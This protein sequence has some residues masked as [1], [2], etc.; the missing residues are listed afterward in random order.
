MG[1]HLYSLLLLLCAPLLIAHVVRKYGRENCDPMVGRRLGINIPDQVDACLWIHACSLGEAKVALE[2]ARALVKHDSSLHV[3]MT[4]TTPV[5]LHLL[6]RSEFASHVFPWDF[7]WVWSRWLARLRP[8]ALVVIETELWPNLVAACYQ[9]AVPVILANG[10]LSDQSVRR[11]G[12]FGWVSRPMW[13]KV[14]RALMQFDGDVHHAHSLGVPAHAISEVGSIKVDQPAPQISWER[15][16]QISDWKRGH[17]L[18]CLM[19]SHADDDALLVA[20]ALQH[21]ELRLLIVPRHPVRGPEIKTLADNHGLVAS[22]VSAEIED[23]AKILIG[24]TFGDMGAYLSQSDVIVIGGSFSG[25]GG[26]NPIEPALMRKPLVAGPSMHNFQAISAGLETAGALLRTDSEHLSGAIDK[27][28]LN[29]DA[30]GQAAR[31]WVEARRGSTELQVK[32]ILAAIT[33]R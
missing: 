15:V 22:M 19:S 20:W 24:D 27:A 14:S 12:R 13:G 16:N 30:M 31:A 18:V 4:A 32:A 29:A 6:A 9:A 8:K 17:V 5:G 3:F 1:R 21:S 28:L 2:L 26:Q 23:K 33:E 7:P 25:K 10:R 11:Y